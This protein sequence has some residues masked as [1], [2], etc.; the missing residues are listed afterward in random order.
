MSVDRLH[1]KIANRLESQGFQTEA[2]RG[3]SSEAQSS[4]AQSAEA[5]SFEATGPSGRGPER[6]QEGSPERDDGQ[7]IAFEAASDPANPHPHSA[8]DASTS[9][10]LAHVESLMQVG[11]LAK[12]TGKTVRAIHLYEKLGLIEPTRRSKGRYRLYSADAKVRVRWISKLQSLGLSL[13]DIQ[14]IVEQRQ[15]SESARRAADE[16]RHV[17]Q[18]KLDEV[19]RTLA[20]LRALQAELEA[21]VAFLS[22]CQHSCTPEVTTECCQQCQRHPEATET[23]PDLIVG[24]QMDATL[25]RA[26]RS[27]MEDTNND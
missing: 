21:S 6:R 2:R 23:A 27:R 11:D 5:Q 15:Q 20:E 1:L 8:T 22:S 17:Y 26:A 19:R 24:A 4:E 3:Q 14:A 25:L 7:E 18:T 16:L 13:T 10:A 9:E 12:A